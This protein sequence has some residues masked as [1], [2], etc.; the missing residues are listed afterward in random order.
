[1][2][3]DA[4]TARLRQL[5]SGYQSTNDGPLN[6]LVRELYAAFPNA[7]YILCLRRGGQDAWWRSF[8]AALGLH[9]RTDW[10]RIMF[11]FLIWPVGFIRRQDDLV[12]KGKNK[13]E[14]DLGIPYGPDVYAKHNEMVKR[15]IPEEKLL[16]FYVDQ[17]W[18][19]LCDFLDV[20]IPQE[21]FPSVNELD[22]MKKIYFGMQ[23]FGALMWMLYI[24][25]FV[26]VMYL[27]FYIP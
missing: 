8:D 4:I 7:K 17:G 19:P 24:G 13:V 22:S 6:H 14:R 11:R 25:G 12:Q 23:A 10:S 20:D 26:V 1:M 5:L 27:A 2:S 18:A 15:V 21:S 16:V 3:Q 9:F